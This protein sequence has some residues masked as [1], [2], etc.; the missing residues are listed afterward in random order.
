MEKI[1]EV[2]KGWLLTSE[3]VN[4]IITRLNKLQEKVESLE[5]KVSDLESVPPGTVF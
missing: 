3:K 2:E 5:K 1:K 4:Q